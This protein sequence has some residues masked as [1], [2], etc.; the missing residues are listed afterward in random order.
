ML[1]PGLVCKV[2]PNDLFTSLNCSPPAPRIA[3][4]H[5]S[6]LLYIVGG[7]LLFTIA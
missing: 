7:D 6:L 1:L 5:F 2:G 3:E 4:S